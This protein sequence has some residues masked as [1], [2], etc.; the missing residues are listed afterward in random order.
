MERHRNAVRTGPPRPVGRWDAPGRGRPVT[1]GILVLAVC[2]PTPAPLRGAPGT[3]PD[4]CRVRPPAEWFASLTQAGGPIT[5][6]GPHLEKLIFPLGGIG[7]GTIWLH[8]SGRLVHWQIFNNIQKDCQVDGSFFAV[9]VEPTSGPPQTR[10][11]C[12]DPVGS[13][14]GIADATFVGRY[15]VA[16][17]ALR[18]PALPLE[19][20]LEAFNPLIPLAEQDSAL[21]CAIFTVRARNRGDQPVRV[22]FLASLQNAVGHPGRGA[23]R[24]VSHAGYGGNMNRLLRDET[25][26]AVLMRASPGRPGRITPPMELLVDH[27][28]L[29]PGG[30]ER[31][32]GLTLAAAGLPKTSAAVRSVYW[33]ARGDVRLLGG[34]TLAHIAEAVRVH[35]AFLLLD[36]PDNPLARP[37]AATAEAGQDRRETAFAGFDDARYAQWTAEGPAMGQGPKRGTLPDQNPVSGFTGA[38]LIN[39]F[40]GGDGPH[41]RL[42]SPEF[43]IKERYISLL[44]GGGRKPGACGVNLLVDGNIVRTATGEDSERLGRV[45]WD[46]TEFENRAARIEIVDADSGPWGHVLVD[47]IRFSNLPIDAITEEEARAWNRL[48]EPLADASPGASAGVGRGRVMI[49][50]AEFLPPAGDEP[51]IRR[52]AL[53]TRLAQLA[54]AVYDPPAGQPIDAPSFG[55]MCLASPDP[56]AAALTTWTDE[57]ALLNHPTGSARA[58]PEGLRAPSDS[59]WTDPTPA[60]RTINAALRVDRTVGPGQAAEAVFV[61]AWHFPNQHYPHNHWRPEGGRTQ[62]VG[63]MYANWY[64]DAG[65]VARAVVTGLQRLRAGTMAYRD[66]LFD[67]TL[68]QYLVDAVA[69][70]ASIPRSPTCFW[71]R[72]GTFYGYEGCSPGGGGCCPMNCNHVWNYAQTVAH[73]WPALE[74][75]MRVTELDYHQ[76][77]DGAIHHRVS[78]PRDRARP[79]HP[80]ADGQC[81]AVLKAYREHLRS[82]DRRF[83]DDHWEKI[84]RA[85]DYA[86]RTWDTDGDGVMEQP[87]FN[88]YDREIFG[89]NTFVS[90]LYLAALRAAENMARLCRDDG[91]AARYRDLFEKGRRKIAETLFNG[92]YYIQAADRIE[93]GYGTGCWSDQVVGAW[94]ARVLGLG[95]ILPPEQ[96]RSALAAIFRHNWLWSMEGFEG[97]QR[98]REFADGQDKGLLCGTW[99][100]GGRPEDPILYRDECWTGVEYQVAAHKLYEGQIEEALAVVRG[101]RQ[102]YDGTRRSPW[103]EIE[104]GDYYVRAMSSWS[105]LTAAQGFRYDG[106]AGEIGFDPR[107]SPDDHRSLF[108]AARGWGRFVQRR[109]DRRQE[110]RVEMIAGRLDLAVLR[111]GLPAEA[112]SATGRTRIDDRPLSVEI[113]VS[114]SKA[115]VRMTPPIAVTAGQTLQVDLNW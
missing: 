99:P 100:R 15:P 28:L 13:L 1:T 19:L 77:D 61:I 55:T 62:P 70:N 9:R 42:V 29:P 84:R 21:P 52:E 46:V 104:C 57:A 37:I 82:A 39:S 12:R 50:P 91:A 56:Q 94:W 4:S 31:V 74:R 30:E 59:P 26:T 60:G 33:L 20:E 10:V 102:R 63:V 14:P 32:E 113:A 40:E 90:S 103:N 43:I 97:T 34:S 23:S 8:G 107:L 68:P 6:S 36:G 54:G 83:L 44:V 76:T 114:D 47:D 53:L 98:F 108:T 101:V 96:V 38:G 69:A 51:G 86:I 93:Q 89:Q 35:G 2:A 49:T 72:D 7:T 80:A 87:Q 79:N 73:L 65:A 81:G 78:V 22:A 92:E 110:C 111:L 27:D 71:T 105:L 24:G 64:A 41:G 88:T 67:T 45:E 16:E 3:I 25:M 109:R 18:D 5:Y 115:E 48:L 17:L 66:A 58:V 85:M 11:L 112:R 75:D 106:P 95:D